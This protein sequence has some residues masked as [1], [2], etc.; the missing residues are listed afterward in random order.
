MNFI[1]YILFGYGYFIIKK[2]RTADLPG[3]LKE[4][5]IPDLGVNNDIGNGIIKF[6]NEWKKEQK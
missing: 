4:E 3:K 1:W 5:S 6:D 2:S